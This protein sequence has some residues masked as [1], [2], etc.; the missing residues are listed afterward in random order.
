MMLNWG[1]FLNYIDMDIAGSGFYFTTLLPNGL[2][3]V[4]PNSSHVHFEFLIIHF[5]LRKINS[6]FLRAGVFTKYVLAKAV[7]GL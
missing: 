4:P 7:S 3:S 5:Q 1:D 6:A 2:E